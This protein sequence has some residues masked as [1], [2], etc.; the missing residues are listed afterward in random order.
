M[1]LQQPLE[2]GTLCA[3]NI[4]C[5]RTSAILLSKATFT[6]VTLKIIRWLGEDSTEGVIH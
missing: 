4:A 6:S 5:L 1:I 3:V 2:I